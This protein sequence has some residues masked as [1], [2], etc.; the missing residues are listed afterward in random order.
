MVPESGFVLGKPT[1]SCADIVLYDLV[2][3]N[4]PGLVALKVDV[5]PYKNINN[6]VKLVGEVEG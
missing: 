4:F 3:S 5:S 6:I 2:N 1:P